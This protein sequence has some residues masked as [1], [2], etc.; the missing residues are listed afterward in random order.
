MAKMRENTPVYITLSNINS[1]FKVNNSRTRLEL[2][3][4]LI[5]PAFDDYYAIGKIGKSSMD[6]IRL[7]VTK[8]QDEEY[9]QS[10]N[11]AERVY[12]SFFKKN[13]DKYEKRRELWSHIFE[14]WKTRLAKG[15]PGYSAQVTQFLQDAVLRESQERSILKIRAY[16][17]KYEKA[18]ETGDKAKLLTVLTLL[19]ITRSY[20]GEI[21]F[22]D[23]LPE[24]YDKSPVFLPEEDPLQQAKGLFKQRQYQKAIDKLNDLVQIENENGE[25]ET[26]E[27]LKKSKGE[28]FYLLSEIYRELR[29]QYKK[30]QI[31]YQQYTDEI[32]TSLRG[33]IANQHVPS[34]L[35]AAREYF[36]VQES[37]VFE[38]DASRC[39]ELSKSII[40]ANAESDE[41]GE[42]F[43]MLYCLEPDDEKAEE[44]LQKSASYSYP[45]AVKKWTEKHTVSLVQ[46]LKQS[47]D[48]TTG[49]FYINDT[50]LYSDLI[51]KTAAK[52]WRKCKF[53]LCQTISDVRCEK[54]QIN[55]NGLQRY[56]LVSDDFNQN[57]KELLHLL[58]L[59]KDNSPY[60][61]DNQIEFFIRGIEDEIAPFIDTALAGI[62]ICIP[63]HLLDDN[64]LAARVLAKHPLFYPIRKLG[65][66]KPSS[67]NFIVV[68]NTPCC[69]WV[70]R[71]AFWMLT[72]RNRNIR[73]KITIIAPDSDKV[74]ARL[75]FK[76]P[77]MDNGKLSGSFP[78]MD[79][80]PCDFN[81]IGIVTEIEKRMNG[82]NAYLVIDT[83]LGTFNAA[84]AIKIREI[85]IRRYIQLSDDELNKEFPVIAFRCQ[86]PD[87]ANLTHRSIVLNE[88]FGYK[89]FN[90]Y[91]LIPFGS[92]EQ[93][94]HW[95]AL[96]NNLFE[97]LGLNVHLQYYRDQ[98]L[99]K[100]N[101]AEYDKK[102]KDAEKAF[103]ARS[104]NR[105]SSIAVAMSLPYRMYQCSLDDKP[106]LPIGLDPLENRPLS[107][108]DDDSF[109]SEDALKSYSIKFKE[110]GVKAAEASGKK[111]GGWETAEYQKKY[112]IRVSANYP[113]EKQGIFLDESNNLCR[114]S[115]EDDTESE[116]YQLAE[117]E[118]NRWIRFMIS[119]GWTIAEIRHM[120]L[121]YQEENKRQQLYIGKMHPCIVP[122]EKISKVDKA[123]NALT[124][125]L[126]SFKENDISA[127]QMT[128]RVLD[129]E[130]TK[131]RDAYLKTKEV[132]Q[133]ER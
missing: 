101:A 13:G 98:A 31:Q 106:I 89:W 112:K 20:W 39:I 130:W 19:S 46:T 12:R 127:I 131:T 21:D 55:L 120:K 78:E 38:V 97:R 24:D 17:D 80:V 41:C 93:N 73:T 10:Y 95:D 34:M 35:E 29:C 16:L 118:H 15:C 96:T 125:K 64:K 82:E 76:C 133:S 61:A 104:Y 48:T 111:S 90:N 88:S 59:V 99:L 28:A 51:C 71:E 91:A 70:L 84:L 119:R 110:A 87:I 105:D 47:T 53:P 49:L 23:I 123:W 9:S 14:A 3:Q 116:L 108:L 122:Y 45:K 83:G 132:E 79:P 7:C 86:D 68:G 18:T 126:G 121:Y 56:F 5:G 124:G 60:L 66:H 2:D 102:Y 1:L 6:R 65:N 75:K 69:E 117:W 42:A 30:E 63:V 4:L 94:Y 37:S 40:T 72:F 100:G 62:S 32:K 8:N 129:M 22:K 77:D 33:A 128:E 44:Y 107:I 81:T 52:G 36:T 50:N 43:W 57:L 109:F 113:S 85:A 115:I 26:I 54:A 92:A 11:A 103:W 58:Q 27:N 67:L 114:Y 74:I 25:D